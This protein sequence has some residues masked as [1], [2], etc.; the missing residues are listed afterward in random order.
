MACR[1]EI[2]GAFTAAIKS[3]PGGRKTV[4]TQDFFNELAKATRTGLS[5]RPI[6]R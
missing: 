4:S 6:S 5:T 1:Y 3:E 2:P